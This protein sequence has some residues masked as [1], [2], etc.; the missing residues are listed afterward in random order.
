M[1]VTVKCLECDAVLFQ[2]ERAN[3]LKVLSDF[4]GSKCENCGRKLGQ[5]DIEKL[6]IAPV[7][8]PTRQ[9]FQNKKVVIQ[10]GKV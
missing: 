6:V 8:R 10:D 3:L 4:E 5:P 2:A 7:G 9:T 1:P